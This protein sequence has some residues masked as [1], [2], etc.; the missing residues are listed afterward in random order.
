MSGWRR[1]PTTTGTSAAS[2][3]STRRI[4][5]CSTA[6][7]VELAERGIDLPVVWG[8]RNWQPYLVGCRRRGARERLD[9]PARHRDQRVQLVL[10]LP[11]VPRGFRPRAVGRRL[12]RRADRQGAAVLRPPRIRGALRRRA[13][14]RPRR[15]DRTRFRRRRDPRAV[16][17][18]QHPDRRR[19]AQRS[20]RRRRERVSGTAPRGRRGD[21]GARP[22]PGTS[23]SWSTRAAP[24]RAIAAVARARRQRCDRDPAG[25]GLSKPS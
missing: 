22:A 20:A 14:H 4:A 11:A 21:H 1:S 10:E 23:G 16:R 25:S 2:A 5:R 24:A 3:R 8:N 12:R 17:H 18:P 19:R 6:L 13:A 7:R 9:P 15:P